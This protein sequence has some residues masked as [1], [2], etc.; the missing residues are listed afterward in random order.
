MP[1][2][3]V[4]VRLWHGSRSVRLVALVDSGADGS[5]FDANYADLL[6]LDRKDA[7]TLTSIG[8]GGTAISPVCWP[9]APLE[10][11]FEQDR[12]PFRGCFIDFS[13]QADGMNLLGRADF[14][15]NYIIQ[16]WD[17]AQ[18]LNIDASP[19]FPRPPL[20]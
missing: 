12:F 2:P 4:E 3:L 7:Q 17:A 13:R 16:F 18:L 6:G 1:L 8:A 19:D 10:I 20:S 14:F 5:L 9:N 11:Q 15:Q